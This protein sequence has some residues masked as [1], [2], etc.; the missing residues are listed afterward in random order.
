[1]KNCGGNIMYQK[2]LNESQ[3]LIIQVY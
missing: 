1:V 3:I 2:V